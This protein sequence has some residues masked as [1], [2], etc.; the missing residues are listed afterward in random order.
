MGHLCVCIPL[1][2]QQCLLFMTSSLKLSPWEKRT[3]K[4]VDVDCYVE[5]CICP[6]LN[7]PTLSSFCSQLQTRTLGRLVPLCGRVPQFQWALFCILNI[8]NFIKGYTVVHEYWIEERERIWLYS[9]KIRC[10]VMFSYGLMI[11]THQ[12][13]LDENTE[14]KINAMVKKS[15][16]ATK[17]HHSRC[18]N[19][20]RL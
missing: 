4:Q 13:V 1:P 5:W 8:Q 11:Q 20:I 12:P 17:L 10:S 3:W 14:R 9:I 7:Y 18:R 16:V 15:R 6:Q 2:W 19:S